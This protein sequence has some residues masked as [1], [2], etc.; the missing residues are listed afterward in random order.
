MGRDE[1]PMP[2]QYVKPFAKT[3]ATSEAVSRRLSEQL[4]GWRKAE[5]CRE[6]RR[7]DQLLHMT[8]LI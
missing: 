7:K 3:E 1:R 4:G 6:D 2:E 5:R 8:P